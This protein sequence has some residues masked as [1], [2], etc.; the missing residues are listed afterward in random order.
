MSGQMLS[1]VEGI[2]DDAK[3]LSLR[4]VE[5]GKRPGLSVEQVKAIDAAEAVLCF[6]RRTEL[7]AL[8]KTFEDKGSDEKTE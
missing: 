5:F 3:R 8:E 7:E 2:K 4:L 6:W 1:E